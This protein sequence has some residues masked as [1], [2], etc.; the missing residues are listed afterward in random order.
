MRKILGQNRKDFTKHL[1]Q[2]KRYQ[3]KQP[4]LYFALLSALT[5]NYVSIR[6][7][8]GVAT[9]KGI[10]LPYF[11]RGR[12]AKEK[13]SAAVALSRFINTANSLL[14]YV[15]KLT[16]S[17]SLSFPTQDEIKQ[18]EVLETHQD[19]FKSGQLRALYLAFTS[20]ICF[21]RKQ[22]SQELKTVNEHTSKNV[23]LTLIA[24][25][26]VNR[27]VKGTE[28][29]STSGRLNPWA[30]SEQQKKSASQIMWNFASG[31]ID[32]AGLRDELKE[33][34]LTPAAESGTLGLI[35][36]KLGTNRQ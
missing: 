25:Y 16:E 20:A 17:K 6:Q 2:I 22:L 36:R 8:E 7:N 18:L 26:V 13:E 1:N 5:E 24:K 12:T 32:Q 34:N 9:E 4:E 27:C 29:T 23:L 10:Y 15:P 33:Q 30:Y 31:K 35:Y 21:N 3:E 14:H 19:A 11:G 28:Y